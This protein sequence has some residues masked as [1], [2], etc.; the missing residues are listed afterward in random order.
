VL[1][2]IGIIPTL[3]IYVKKVNPSHFWSEGHI[4]DKEK[5]ADEVINY[6][7]EIMRNYYR[8]TG[9]AE[10]G[11]LVRDHKKELIYYHYKYWPHEN[12][13]IIFERVENIQMLPEDDLP[14]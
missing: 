7:E 14:N 10:E 2:N 12:A 6:E 1:E 5:T 8:L 3:K 11:P 9:E 4:F 13:D